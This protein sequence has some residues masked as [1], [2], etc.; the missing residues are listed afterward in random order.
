MRYDIPAPHDIS[1]PV[2][3][4]HSIARMPSA[5]P[6]AVAYHFRAL[7]GPSIIYAVRPG[8]RIAGQEDKQILAHITYRTSTTIEGMVLDI[9]N[10]LLVLAQRGLGTPNAE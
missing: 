2:G 6:G 7:I 3:V 4:L 1:D 5:A 9:G 8:S 10:D